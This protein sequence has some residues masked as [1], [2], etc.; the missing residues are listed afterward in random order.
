MPIRPVTWE[1]DVPPSGLLKRAARTPAVAEIPSLDQLRSSLMGT[2]LEFLKI[3]AF[4]V[5]LLAS[6]GV[7]VH[8][9]HLANS[10][11]Q[12]AAS[13]DVAMRSLADA[14]SRRTA[15][16]RGKLEA[17][18][19]ATMH[20]TRRIDGVH[21]LR[22]SDQTTSATTIASIAAPVVERL[23]H[24]SQNYEKE[25]AAN[26]VRIDSAPL[27]E[28]IDRGRLHQTYS[29]LRGYVSP[30]RLAAGI[31]GLFFYMLFVC[32]LLRKKGGLRAFSRGHA[33]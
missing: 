1:L 7:A 23:R 33:V 19:P 28:R 24:L 32:V 21:Q 15:S 26:P 27:Q 30:D 22:R 16:N 18:A 10:N 31:L 13:A 4:A 14:V 5:F 20:N 6:V 11:N 9:S 25:R 12:F 17:L 8:G 2:R 29:I 3:S